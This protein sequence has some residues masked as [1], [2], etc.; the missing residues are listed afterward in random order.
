M[1]KHEFECTHMHT[2]T[3]HHTVEDTIVVIHRWMHP[4]FTLHDGKFPR[5]GLSP[6]KKKLLN[7][8]TLV[9]DLPP[10]NTEEVK[11]SQ[12]VSAL[13]QGRGESGG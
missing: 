2:H 13:S 7:A 12:E 1:H 9:E 11:K 4:T 5:F 6:N 3:C 8:D 10:T